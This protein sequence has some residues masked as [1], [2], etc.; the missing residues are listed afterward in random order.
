[1]HVVPP[2]DDPVGFDIDEWTAVELDRAIEECTDPAVLD[3]LI[4]GLLHLSARWVPQDYQRLPDGD[5][6]VFAFLAGRYTGKTDSGSANTNAHACGP[7][8]DA[9]VP[10]GHRMR[11]VGPTHN[12]TVASC[13]NG[14]TG[15]RAHNPD[16]ELVGSKEG[17]LVR[18]PNGAVARI[19]GAYTPEDAER[20]RAAGNSCFDWYEELAAW[21]QLDRVWEQAEFGLR[22]GP[23]PRAII[24][25]SPKN[26]ARIKQ[27]KM[28]GERYAADPAAA[29]SRFERVALR[30]ASTRDNRYGNEDVRQ[31]LYAR[32]AGTRLGRQ[33]LDAEIVEDLGLMFSSVWFAA[34]DPQPWAHRVRYWDLAGTEPGA[35]NE[36]PDWTAGVLVA[37]DPTRRRWTLPDGSNI[38]AGRFQVQHVARMRGAPGEVENLILRTARADGPGTIQVIEQDPGQAG[39][40]QVAHYRKL[41]HSI[42]SFR[43]WRPSGSKIVRAELASSAAQQGRVS[44][45]RGS[46]TQDFFD[47]AEQFPSPDIH[48]DQ[49]DALSGA[50]A[51]LEDRTGIARSTL[52]TGSTLPSTTLPSTLTVAR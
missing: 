27:L 35:N 36:D 10:G 28:L 6:S 50:F 16:V 11:L 2:A 4:A 33:E 5:W 23:N 26:R 29:G 19:M 13:V 30:I 46:W 40:S 22:L 15:L 49:I 51:V 25:T 37:H 52:P 31:S 18:W 3:V 21:R 24:T 17:T 20:F 47:E 39:K 8:C 43:E 34:E 48:D 1:M 44:Y 42:A 7:P 45:V 12:D 32:Y 14:P 38:F 41:L 9:R